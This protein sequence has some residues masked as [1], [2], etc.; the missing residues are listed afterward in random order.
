MIRDIDGK[1]TANLMLNGERMMFLR[2]AT[3]QR[4]MFLP[5]SSNIVLKLLAGEIRQEK[6]TKRIWI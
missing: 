5:L 6:E 2:S 4:C 3:R 1:P